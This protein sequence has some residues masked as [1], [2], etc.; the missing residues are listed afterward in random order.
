MLK[1]IQP[2]INEVKKLSAGNQYYLR[3]FI[4]VLVVINISGAMG[5]TQDV[6]PVND[7]QD[8]SVVNDEPETIRR[9]RYQ[10]HSPQKATLLS[11][12]LPGMG[13]I[14]NGRAWKVPIIYAGFG[15]IAYFVR[16]NNTNYQEFR[17]AYM[18]RVDGNPNTVPDEKF[19]LY[20]TD[21]LKSGMNYYRRN[22]EITFI[23]AA[24]LYVLNILD[25]TVDAHLLDF[26]VG[27]DLTLKLRPSLN[28]AIQGNIALQNPTAGF[29]LTLRF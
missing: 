8:V 18:A 9:D 27:E 16:F 23:A 19:E 25:A 3:C 11:A 29:T 6:S 10:D 12:T 24:A 22:L 5:Y 4:I 15:T 20:R 26:D 7:T 14:Y 2:I 1:N 28:P 21:N 17:Q 13:Q